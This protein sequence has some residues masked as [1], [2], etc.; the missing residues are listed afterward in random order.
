LWHWSES[1]NQI[2]EISSFGS[3]SCDPGLW[4]LALAKMSL[5]IDSS[6]NLFCVW[7]GFLSDDHSDVD[8][9]HDTTF[10]NGDLYM[11]YSIDQG[12]TWSIR[13]NITVTRTPDCAAGQCDS[14]NWATLAEEVDDYLH[15]LYVDDKDA[16]S[17]PISEGE[18]T[19]N[20]IRY[21]E[22]PNPLSSQIIKENILPRDIQVLRCYPNPFNATTLLQFSL[23]HACQVDLR[24]Y[25]IAGRLVQVIQSRYLLAGGHEVIWDAGNY[26]SGVYLGRLS[27]GDASASIKLVISK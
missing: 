4:N 18:I 17:M 15:V 1:S 26:S 21:L 6:D 7:T 5:G 12:L 23:R 13:Q 8:P 20:P 27:A 11:S 9:N 3:T 2:T 22:I 19:D 10:C 14:D 16:G 24:I 25:D